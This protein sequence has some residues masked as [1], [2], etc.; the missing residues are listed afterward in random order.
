MLCCAANKWTFSR[1]KQGVKP[2]PFPFS[3][4]PRRSQEM[5]LS[6]D[7]QF[8]RKTETRAR[9]KARAQNIVYRV[10]LWIKWNKLKWEKDDSHL[11]GSSCAFT[12][13]LKEKKTNKLWAT[14]T[15][16]VEAKLP[17]DWSVSS[18][19]GWAAPSRCGC[20]ESPSQRSYCRI[21]FPGCTGCRR[22]PRGSRRSTCQ[23]TVSLDRFFRGRRRGRTKRRGGRKLGTYAPLTTWMVLVEVL[24]SNSSTSGM[25]SVTSKDLSS[26]APSCSSS[27]ISNIT[28]M[29]STR[30]CRLRK[31]VEWPKFQ[32]VKWIE[33]YSGNV[34]ER[35]TLILQI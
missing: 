7:V 2:Q 12:V 28:I 32:E 15:K 6:R 10:T 20:P 31:S 14:N 34:F 17:L 9:I 23:R 24:Y 16:I 4:R 29:G 26:C 13:S 30:S 33:L 3:Q 35:T 1:H 19:A 27:G 11:I 22:S 21:L 25:A 5:L 8:S 18:P